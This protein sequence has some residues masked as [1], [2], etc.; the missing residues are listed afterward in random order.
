MSMT[1]EELSELLATR[2]PAKRREAIA[3]YLEPSSSVQNR[4]RPDPDEP[5]RK[6]TL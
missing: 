1:M 4:E 6:I 5:V 3:R 2:D